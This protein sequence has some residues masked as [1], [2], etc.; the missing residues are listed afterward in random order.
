MLTEEECEEA[1]FGDCAYDISFDKLYMT[2][3]LKITGNLSKGMD[4]RPLLTAPEQL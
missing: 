3:Q 4:L 1:D 2:G